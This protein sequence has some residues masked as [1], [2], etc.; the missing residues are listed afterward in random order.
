MSGCSGCARR[1]LAALALAALAPAGAAARAG[2]AATLSHGGEM[3]LRGEAFDNILDLDSR[4]DDSYQFWRFRYRFWLDARPR[5]GLRFYLRLGNEYRFGQHQLASIR[6]PESRVSLDN[7]WAEISRRGSTASPGAPPGDGIALR[8][9]RMDLMY[10]EGFLIFDGTP[11]DGSAS[12]YFDAIQAVM[13]RGAARLDLFTAKLKDEA[14]GGAASDEDL[15]GLYLRRG[16][17]E[18][19]LLHRF[20]RGADISQA[21]QPWQVPQ[22]R[23]RTT[24]FGARLTHLPPAGWQGAMEGA[25]QTG[26]YEDQGGGQAS[27]ANTRLGRG[28]YA[29]GGYSGG[30]GLRPGAEAG[31][32]YLSGDDPASARYEGWDD[33]YAQWPKWSELL[34]YTFYD[35]TT[36]VHAPGDPPRPDDA[37][38]W[39]NLTALWLE[40]RARPRPELTLAAR[41]M[42]LGAPRANGP[43]GGRDRGALLILRADWAAAPDVA[44]QAWLEYFDPGGFYAPGADHAWYA[45]LQVTASH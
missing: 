9:G 43:G 44:V 32:L 33:F 14:F 45:R 10:G 19:Y 42:R 39:T 20:Q 37:G 15:H 24:A 4:A 18:A 41:G 27:V 6:D 5:D 34:I 21:G 16:G 38:A 7:G 17:V 29:R 28:G 25:L 35:L 13:R 36:R 12:A 3:R 2:E 40:G 11:A 23:Q 8:F 1:T 31:V 22:H 26:R 30:G